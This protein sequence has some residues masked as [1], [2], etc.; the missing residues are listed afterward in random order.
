MAESS[1]GRCARKIRGQIHVPAMCLVIQSAFSSTMGFWRCDPVRASWASARPARAHRGE[2]M[3][4]RM[5]ANRGPWGDWRL[6]CNQ[7]GVAEVQSMP[8]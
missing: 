3:D 2:R 4:V 6:G 5:M 7:L 8:A 1:V